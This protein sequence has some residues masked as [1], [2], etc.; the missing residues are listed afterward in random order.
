MIPIDACACFNRVKKLLDENTLGS[1][2]QIRRID[3]CR[4]V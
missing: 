2:D 4:L 1:D 3:V